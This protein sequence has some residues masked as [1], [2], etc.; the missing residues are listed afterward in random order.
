MLLLVELTSHGEFCIKLWNGSDLW[1]QLLWI[2]RDFLLNLIF[3][4]AVSRMLFCVQI[5]HFYTHR[6]TSNTESLNRVGI[7]VLFA[8]LFQQPFTE[9]HSRGHSTPFAKAGTKHH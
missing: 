2:P 1:V 3:F 8:F 6:V 9:K 5:T 4:Q 7:I